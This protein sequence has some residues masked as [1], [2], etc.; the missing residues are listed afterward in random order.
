MTRE[1]A[2]AIS[3]NARRTAPDGKAGK[4]S[5]Q[6]MPRHDVNE[7]TKDKA[8]GRCYRGSGGERCACGP[9]LTGKGISCGTDSRRRCEPPSRL[10]AEQ[11]RTQPLSCNDSNEPL[12][13]GDRTGHRASVALLAAKGGTGFLGK[14]ERSRASDIRC[15]FA[16]VKNRRLFVQMLIDV[17]RTSRRLA[18]NSRGRTRARPRSWGQ[19]F[20]RSLL[21]Q[22]ARGSDESE[23][24]VSGNDSCGTWRVRCVSLL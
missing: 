7:M 21:A 2:P 8:V 14:L 1:W 13:V 10:S 24:F 20:G 9:Q 6:W 18:R 12:T 19:P 15:Q 23:Q 22:R 5:H 17:S 11:A 3:N 16:C 4:G